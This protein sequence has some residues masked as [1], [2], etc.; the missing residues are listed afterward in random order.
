M[1]LRACRDKPS[2]AYLCMR[3]RSQRSHYPQMSFQS[4]SWPDSRNFHL[5][6]TRDL[7]KSEA[8]ACFR[9]KRSG[10][11]WKLSCRRELEIK[12]HASPLSTHTDTL[13]PHIIFYFNTHII[14]TR[15]EILSPVLSIP[16]EVFAPTGNTRWH[17]HCRR[18]TPK[19]LNIFFCHLISISIQRVY[20]I[21]I[22]Y[23][24]K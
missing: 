7:S 5:D 17:L 23:N 18:V 6:T 21:G 15:E 8:R 22:V 24:D 13:I 12:R 20:I 11:V 14:H 16:F 10:N 19:S 4:A 3:I 1:S 9:S 2:N